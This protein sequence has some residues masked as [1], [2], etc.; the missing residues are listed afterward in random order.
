MQNAPAEV[1]KTN[2][3]YGLDSIRI[4]LAVVVM[5][6]HLHKPLIALPAALHTSLV[7]KFL[8]AIAIINGPAA[9]IAFFVLSGFVIHFPN[10]KKESFDL[11]RF[12]I[13]RLVR[14]SLP[15]IAVNLIGIYL[16]TYKII[17]MWS[18]YCEMAYYVIYP[19]L[20]K[21][22]ASWNVKVIGSFIVAFV[23]ILVF[24]F[25]SILSLIHQKDIDYM[26][27]YWELGQWATIVIGLPCWLLGVKMADDLDKLQGKQVSYSMLWFYRIFTY[28]VSVVL[29]ILDF[30][31]FFTYLFSLNLLAFLIVQWLQKEIIYYQS[32][33]TIPALEYMG[34]FSYTLYLWH[35]TLYFELGHLGLTGSFTGLM[36][37]LVALAVSYVLYLIIEYPSHKFAIAISDR[38]K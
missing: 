27:Q 37:V 29:V 23:L 26:S 9:V 28:G 8:K 4:V 24:N 34:K 7:D 20:F 2:W 15:V 19:A 25:G 31:F 38:F 22:K 18:L 36:Y 3:I 32:H 14:I 21:I 5:L 30:H 6:S 13:R 11:K 35:G 16:G 12:Y 1:K 33:P 17:P 10:R